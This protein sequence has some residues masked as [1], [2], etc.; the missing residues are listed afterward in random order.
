MSR[1][2]MPVEDIGA[3]EDVPT[4]CGYCGARTMLDKSAAH[5]DEPDDEHCANVEC[6]QRY[7]V[8]KD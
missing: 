5:Y 4:T 8:W 6:G 2:T 3:P 7:R 1:S